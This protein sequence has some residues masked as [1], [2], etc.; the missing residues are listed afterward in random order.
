MKKTIRILGIRGVPAAHGGFE[1]FA[2][3]LTPYLLARGWE[4]IVYCQEEGDGAMYES[5]WQGVKRI[6]IPV[7][8][9]GAKS[10]VVFDWISIVHASK[11]Q[12]LCLTLGYNTA[13]FCALLRLKGVPNVMNMDGIEWRRGKWGLIAKAWFWLNEWAGSLLSN[14]MIADHPEIQQH[15][16][17]GAA[18][19]KMTMIPYGADR[20]D[21][22]NPEL[23]ARYDLKPNQFCVLI[24]RAE[25]ENSV[26]EVVQ[27]YSKRV[28][29][30]PL[31]VLGN[32]K[33]DQNPFHLAVIT[34]ASD[35]VRFLGA[36]YEKDVVNALRTG[37][38]YYVHGHQVGGTNPSL[39]EALGAGSAVLA[40]DNRFNRW[41][42]AGAGVFFSSIDQCDVIIAELTSRDDLIQQLK[43][44]ACE[45]FHAQF[46]SDDVLE[47]YEKLLLQWLPR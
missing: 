22:I 20:I 18:H 9:N 36:I 7:K 29:G 23:L 10:T 19:S 33:P 17:R 5:V 12:D 40:H 27:A 37:A 35:E 8:G 44:A 1:T 34:A 6:H 24:A 26:L 47:Q 32:Y 13:I 3:A 43:A 28:R 42:A 39:V 15:L 4:V 25:P 2:Q 41:V 21:E 16:A 45:Q 11:H 30:M 38:R 14:H 46:E 31:V